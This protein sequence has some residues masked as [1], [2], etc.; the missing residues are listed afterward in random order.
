MASP[1]VGDRVNFVQE[2][3]GGG[4]FAG[5]GVVV[6]SHGKGRFT[7]KVEGWDI[8]LAFQK[9]ELEVIEDGK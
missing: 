1:K 8:G 3:P 9:D 5:E 4:I 6:A 7:V 2:T